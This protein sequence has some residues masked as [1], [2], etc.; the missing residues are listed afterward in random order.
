V[1]REVRAITGIGGTGIGGTGDSGTGVAPG[2]TL[3]SRW[4]DAFPQYRVHHLLRVTGIESAV[5]RLPALAVAGAAYRGVGIPACVAS[6]R[7]AARTV[8]DALHALPGGA[9]PGG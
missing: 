3:V 7:N 1:I 2:R 9:G 4:P 5:R 6:G 8:L